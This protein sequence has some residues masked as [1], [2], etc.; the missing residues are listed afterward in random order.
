MNKTMPHSSYLE[1]WGLL[2]LKKTNH[3]LATQFHIC[4]N[5]SPNSTQIDINII[6]K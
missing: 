1:V 3:Y 2:H 5:C 4:V 6:G